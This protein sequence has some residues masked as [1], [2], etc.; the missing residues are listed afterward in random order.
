MKISV[1]NVL[2]KKR[3]QTKILKSSPIANLSF[4]TKGLYFIQIEFNNEIK[5]FKMLKN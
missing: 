4:L 1:Y 2:G 3:Y 5:T